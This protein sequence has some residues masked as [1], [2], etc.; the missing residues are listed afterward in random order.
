MIKILFQKLL[1]K[2]GKSYVI[3]TRIPQKLIAAVLLKRSTMLIRGILK[4]GKK[5]FIGS[6]TKIQ[7]P[8]N[9]V[10]GKSV[11]ID[12]H[13]CIDGFSSEKIIGPA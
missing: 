9:I 1:N 6:N 12:E 5:V 8:Q 3:D 2:S 11:T 4:T 10:F 7:N 13:C